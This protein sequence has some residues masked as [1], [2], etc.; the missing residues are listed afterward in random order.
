MKARTLAI[1]ILGLYV[2]L[3]A[4]CLKSIDPVTGQTR[5]GLDPNSRVVAAAE[6]GAGVVGAT[7]PFL[8]PL[9]GLIGGG[10]LTALAAW[11]K[12]KPLLLTA[13]SEAEQYHAAATA[14]VLGIED[15]KK[16]NPE[17]WAKLGALI[18]PQL[19]KVGLTGLQVENVIRA[20]RGLPAKA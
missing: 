1:V 18:E 20:I 13:K 4:G 6:V 3:L 5:V 14:T 8:G 7:L 17:A 16:E 11:R 2:I 12:Y 15:F 9:G 19:G 10:L